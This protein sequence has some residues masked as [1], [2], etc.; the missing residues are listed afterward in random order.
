LLSF[1]QGLLKTIMA[2][3]KHQSQLALR[4]GA[5][6]FGFCAKKDVGAWIST[7]VTPYSL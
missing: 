4:A 3:I 6:G 1:I 7:Y 5:S 2:I